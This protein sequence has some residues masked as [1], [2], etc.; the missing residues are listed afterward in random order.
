M[1]RGLQRQKERTA[2]AERIAKVERGLQIPRGLQRQREDCKCRERG[3]Q[4]RKRI[5]EGMM[6]IFS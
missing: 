6:D 3:Q 1:P 5:I 2:N 4:G